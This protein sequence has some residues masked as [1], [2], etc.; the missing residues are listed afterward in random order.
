MT[1]NGASN[2]DTSPLCMYCHD[3]ECPTLNQT[4]PSSTP[5]QTKLAITPP[6][7]HLIN[8][9]C[10]C[11]G[12]ITSTL[13]IHCKAKFAQFKT[14]SSKNLRAREV[15][16]M[17]CEVCHGAL[18]NG[19]AVLSLA[20]ER[21]RLSL[22]ML[23]SCVGGEASAARDGEYDSDTCGDVPLCCLAEHCMAACFLATNIVKKCKTHVACHG[24]D[25]FWQE[26]CRLLRSTIDTVSE[27]PTSPHQ[28]AL[29]WSCEMK[30][31]DCL[32]YIFSMG[33]NCATSLKQTEEAFLAGVDLVR[34]YNIEFEHLAL[35]MLRM[36][37][38]CA[39][40]AM[41]TKGKRDV[42]GKMILSSEEKKQFV[43]MKATIV[44]A[45]QNA[46]VKGGKMAKLYAPQLSYQVE[47]VNWD[48][49]GKMRNGK[50]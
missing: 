28:I 18:R 36:K 48:T 25:S 11:K 41:N 33:I 46:T 1:I 47:Y 50:L 30:F 13:H 29:A 16:W 10:N 34:S 5:T 14:L 7:T 37:K 44:E 45:M 27:L 31:V 2:D 23:D 42:D 21:Y 20:M 35:S 4:P 9:S 40:S 26:G 17:Y 22:E 6:P 12:T 19:E 3:D 38:F 15:V 39:D 24:D 43:E 49:F 8:L 32:Y